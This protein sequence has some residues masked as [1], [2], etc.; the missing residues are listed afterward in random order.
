MHSLETIN[1]MLNERTT[2]HAKS[3]EQL[4]TVTDMLKETKQ[5]KSNFMEQ[6]MQIQGQFDEDNADLDIQLNKIKT[7]EH[8][9]DKYIPIRVQ[10]LIG[11]TI[12]AVA[13]QS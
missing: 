4:R 10:Q 6:K 13:S 1:T 5:D 2:A 9:I 11:S 7:M 12:A 8:F 3:L